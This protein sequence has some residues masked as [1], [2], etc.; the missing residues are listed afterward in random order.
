MHKHTATQYENGVFLLARDGNNCQC[1]KTMI[2]VPHQQSNITGGVG[3]RP[4]RIECST[5]CPFATI[6]ERTT[7]KETETGGS[8]PD[9]KKHYYTI[10]CEGNGGIEIPLDEVKMFKKP[11][12][13]GNGNL[14]A[15]P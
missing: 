9:G 2:G 10:R 1:P 13:N 3:L 15:M 12:I 4:A 7:F 8:E 11:G 5:L 14:I 6:E